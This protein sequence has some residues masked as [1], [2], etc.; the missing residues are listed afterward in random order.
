MQRQKFVQRNKSPL[1]QCS[2]DLIYSSRP[3]ELAR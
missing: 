2:I 3:I 1:T